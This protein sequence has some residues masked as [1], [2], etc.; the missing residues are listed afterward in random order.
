MALFKLLLKLFIARDHVFPTG[1]LLPIMDERETVSASCS[2]ERAELMASGCDA[3]T[4]VGREVVERIGLV[5]SVLTAMVWAEPDKLFASSGPSLFVLSSG[6]IVC[7]GAFFS[8]FS[9]T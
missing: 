7:W 3:V 4:V 8:R 1:A 2:C 5:S 6:S 9:F